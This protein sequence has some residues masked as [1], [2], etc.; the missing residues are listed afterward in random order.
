[1]K[2]AL[3]LAEKTRKATGQPVVAAAHTHAVLAVLFIETGDYEKAHHHNQENLRLCSL[4][5]QPRFVS[6]YYRTQS[7]LLWCTGDIES[8][9]EAV[10][11]AQDYLIFEGGV[12][13][14][15]ELFTTYKAH[16]QLLKG[17]FEE[18]ARLLEGLGVSA[19][20]EVNFR[21][22][23]EYRILAEL[24]IARGEYPA[25]IRV[26]ARLIDICLRADAG[27]QAL[28]AQILK[29][30]AHYLDA[31]LEHALESLKPAVERA[32]CEPL[33]IQ[34]FISAGEPIAQLLY[35]AVLEGINPE[36]CNQILAAFPAPIAPDKRPQAE[37][38]EALSD[39]EIEVLEQIA[40]GHTNQEI[41]QELILSLYTVK[42]HARNIYSKLGVKNRTEAVAR[43][44]LLGLLPND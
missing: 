30:K 34:A 21:E 7:T 15:D 25:A 12:V 10:Q 40:K 14:F 2:E 6:N 8:A 19:A 32:V 43:G 11:K 20:A 41:A 18:A 16:L 37:L 4:W 1:L 23:N 28:K 24:L 26:L 33:L 5:G 36:F 39:R 17:D 42:S 13:V 22:R 35:Q 44:R 31:D 38:V 27:M 9:F 3:S 29:A